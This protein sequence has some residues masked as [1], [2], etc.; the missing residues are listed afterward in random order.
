MRRVIFEGIY[1]IVAVYI[2]MRAYTH[3]LCVCAHSAHCNAT[4]GCILF[5]QPALKFNL[6]QPITQKCRPREF[7]RRDA[8]E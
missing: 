6:V 1:Q 3:T 7:L 5:K 4:K 8:I 2:I